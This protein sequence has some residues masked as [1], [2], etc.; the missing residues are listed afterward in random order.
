MHSSIMPYKYFLFKCFKAGSHF[1]KPPLSPHDLHYL[2]DPKFRQH[3]LL[4][5]DVACNIISC[6]YFYNVYLASSY[7]EAAIV[8]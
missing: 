1:K 4:M 3:V 6:M 7:R 2:S 5:Q 8:N